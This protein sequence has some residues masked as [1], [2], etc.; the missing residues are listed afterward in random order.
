ML[1]RGAEGR[2]W[3]GRTFM[4]GEVKLFRQTTTTN[5]PPEW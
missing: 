5:C 4:I 1:L 3:W 2:G